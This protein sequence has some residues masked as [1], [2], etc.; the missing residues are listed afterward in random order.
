MIA[1]RLGII[2]AGAAL[3]VLL[4]A[5]P[6]FAASTVIPQLATASTMLGDIISAICYIAC[7]VLIGMIA[8]EFQQHRRIGHMLSEAAGAILVVLLAVNGNTIASGIGLSSA[9]VR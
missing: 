4:A 2:S 1:S 8:W 7:I 6:S 5:R 3:C 9:L